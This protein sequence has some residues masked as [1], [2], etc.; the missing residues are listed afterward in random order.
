MAED[1]GGEEMK[2]NDFIYDQA[3]KKFYQ[4]GFK[5]RE[6]E[7]VGAD[8]VNRWRKGRKAVDAV[9]E[10]IKHGKSAYK[11]MERNRVRK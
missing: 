8:A 10:A 3:Y 5:D 4:E 11:G 7:H 9:S 6:C 1:A 2:P